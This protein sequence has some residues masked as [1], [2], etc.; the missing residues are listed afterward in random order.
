MSSA[1]APARERTR[2][3]RDERRAQ[4]LGVALDLFSRDGFHHV[5]MDDIADRAEVSKPVLYR[6]FPSKLDL[7][8]AVVDQRGDALLAAVDEALAGSGRPARV[9]ADRLRV[10]RRRS[11]RL[12]ALRRRRGDSFRPALRVRRARTTTDVR[13][14]A[15]EH[16]SREAA[17]RHRARGL[18]P[19]DG[20]AA[21]RRTRRTPHGR[22]T[23]SRLAQGDRR[24]RPP[25]AQ[26]YRRRHP[27][28]AGRGGARPASGRVPAADRRPT[29]SGH[30]GASPC[31]AVRRAGGRPIRI[32]AAPHA[33]GTAEDEEATWTSR[34]ACGTCARELVAGVRPDVRGGRRRGR[35]RCERGRPARAR[36]RRGREVIVPAALARLRRDRRATKSAGSASAPSERRRAAV[37]AV[38]SGR[39][40]AARPSG[41]ASHPSAVLGREL[42]EQLRRGAAPGRP[43]AEPTEQRARSPAR[44]AATPLHHA[45]RLADEPPSP[46][47]EPRGQRRPSVAAR[48]RAR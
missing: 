2:M 40:A 48:R 25:P 6:H 45:E 9:R 28:S 47:R 22:A 27:G 46:Q 36:R 18:P 3:P 31:R 15:S 44:S 20:A 38:L 19:L 41:R 39:Q 32:A 30:P 34:S 13:A 29:S 35:G 10:G 33:A 23:G 26:L 43:S 16:A 21:R 11:W 24:T 12:R 7:Y 14:K 8:L 4:V 1:E 5:S 42:A 37:R 17:R